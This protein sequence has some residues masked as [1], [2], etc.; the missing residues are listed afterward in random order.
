[1]L[2]HPALGIPGQSRQLKMPAPSIPPALFDR[3]KHEIL[4][5]CESILTNISF[6]LKR[7]WVLIKYSWY[8]GQQ[9]SPVIVY[10]LVVGRTPPERANLRFSFGRI[11]FFGNINICVF[12]CITPSPFS[13]SNRQLEN[14]DCATH[15]LPSLL[16][17]KV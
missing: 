2:N 10:G 6:G 8:D 1:M 3:G 11:D 16:V 7:T 17:S 15:F 4:C 13:K 12:P 14:R 9:L 5:R